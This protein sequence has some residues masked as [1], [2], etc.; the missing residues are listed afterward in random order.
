MKRVLVAFLAACS[1]PPGDMPDAGMEADAPPD[2]QTT[3]WPFPLP[4]QFPTPR[5]PEGSALT[6]ELAE[7][8]RHLFYDKRLS[9]NGTQA[10]AGCHE[11]ARAF[12]DGR[13]LP[14]GSTGSVLERN[15]MSLTNVAYNPTFTWAN[16][17]LTTLEK[18]ALVPMFGTEPVE[19]G[20]T[21]NEDIVLARL[22]ADATYQSLYAAAYP[23]ASEPI[24]MGQV[25]EALSAFQR[26][27]ISGNAPIDKYRRGEAQLSEA[28]LRGEAL[29]FSERLEC[30]HC[31][32][33]FNFT[34][35]IDEENLAEP[36]VAFFNTGLYNVGGDG[37]FPSTDQGLY[38]LTFVPTDRGKFRP[39]SLRNIAVTEPYMHEGSMATL[40]DV[41]SF[42]ERGGREITTGPNAGDGRS[43]PYK[44][45]FVVGFTLTPE[46]RADLLSFLGSLTDEEFL[47]DPS[48][49][50]P[51]A[52]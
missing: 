1:S 2:A 23:A 32:G 5:L 36:A 7:L 35:A 34:I 6:P 12:T 51:F 27:L 44:S 24:A 10:C 41:I 14:T 39:P 4:S 50:D 43:N 28:A 48:I 13:A 33:G 31:H 21:G 37:S 49:A 18:Q 22:R 25:V 40:D 29:F 11:Q 19:L 8:G 17:I 20:I 30:H 52:P 46:E 38:D 9:G 47:T 16:H 15:S 3:S 42:Y 45:L 26:R